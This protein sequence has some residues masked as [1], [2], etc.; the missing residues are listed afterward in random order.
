MD[1]SDDTPAVESEAPEAPAVRR[2]FPVKSVIA[3]VF[4][5]L[6]GLPVFSTLQPG[7]YERYT[8]LAGRMEGW[9]TSTHARIPCGDCH[10]E[11]GVVGFLAFTAKSIPAFYSQL[12]RGPRPDNLLNVPGREACQ[13]C[14]TSYRQVSSSGDLLIPHRAH[15]EVLEIDCAVCHV[16]LVHSPNERGFNVP[17]MKG[18]LDACHDGEQATTE[19]VACHT[20]KQVP[21][22]HLNEDWLEV[23]SERTETTDCGECHAWSPDY[24]AECHAERPASHSGNWKKL[25]Q[26]PALQRGETPC[27][28]CHEREFCLECHD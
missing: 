27:A 11:P 19:C 26:Y 2:R 28:T 12:A 7:Y 3:L 22:D 23:H 1:Q 4:I 9:R 18:C 14:H 20:R 17:E 25:H 16:S 21:D 5:A 13:E 15:V 24:C 10:V 8:D 6:V